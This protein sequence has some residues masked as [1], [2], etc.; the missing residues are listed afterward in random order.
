MNKFDLVEQVSKKAGLSKKDTEAAVEAIFAITELTLAKKE[1]VKISGFGAFG[2][3][4]RKGRLGVNPSTGKKIKIPAA[5]VV[6][7]K[8]S[9]KLKEKVAVKAKGKK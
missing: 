5:T 8:A 6:V 9:K 7:F 1:P 3:R 2:V 4:E